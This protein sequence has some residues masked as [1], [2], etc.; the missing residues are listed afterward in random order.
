MTKVTAC[1]HEALESARA[2]HLFHTS[3]SGRGEQVVL[4]TDVRAGSAVVDI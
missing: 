1:P 3:E 2:T 4:H